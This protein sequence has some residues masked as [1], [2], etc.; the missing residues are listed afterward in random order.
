MAQVLFYIQRLKN[1]PETANLWGVYMIQQ[2]SSKLLA[3]PSLT[4][5]S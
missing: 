3:N 2:T 5:V 4:R 1:Y